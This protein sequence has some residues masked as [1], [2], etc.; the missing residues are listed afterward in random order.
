VCSSDLVTQ[1]TSLLHRTV[2]ENILY[3]RP[4][5]SD[6]DVRS[7]A[8]RARAEEFIEGLSDS[9][10]ALGYDAMVGERG[11]KLSGGQRQRI[12]LARVMLKDAPILL[13]D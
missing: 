7:A 8:R 11:V 9:R 12:A 6:A 2:R 4:Q 13:L 5:A 3:G 10:G 1:D